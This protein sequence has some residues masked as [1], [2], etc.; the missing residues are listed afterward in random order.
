MYSQ[1][2]KKSSL[3]TAIDHLGNYFFLVMQVFNKRYKIEKSLWTMLILYF[4]Q[5]N[6]LLIEEF[7]MLENFSE[8]FPLFIQNILNVFNSK[9]IKKDHHQIT[10][11]HS[12]QSVALLRR[13]CQDL[14]HMLE[15][16]S[17]NFTNNRRL[18]THF[19]LE[20]E[21]MSKSINYSI[22]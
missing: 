2:L 17:D 18:A 12:N 4:S 19:F 1:Q 8:K 20:K 11:Q 7:G 6:D 15:I 14:Y 16:N 9:T 22:I 21:V 10:R 3:K 13:D 5:Y